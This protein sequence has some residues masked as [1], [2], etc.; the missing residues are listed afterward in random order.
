VTEEQ[1]AEE[2]R[3][4]DEKQAAKVAMWAEREAALGSSFN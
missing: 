4:N 2:I 1:E 3:L